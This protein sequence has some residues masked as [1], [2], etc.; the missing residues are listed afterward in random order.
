MLRRYRYLDC[1]EWV[2]DGVVVASVEGAGKG[3][4]LAANVD[5]P[6]GQYSLVLLLAVE[7]KT[8]TMPQTPCPQVMVNPTS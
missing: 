3:R 4:G 8:A 6:A 7:W 1:A 5:I 2:H